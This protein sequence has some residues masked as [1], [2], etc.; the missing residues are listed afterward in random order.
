MTTSLKRAYLFNSSAGKIESLQELKKKF[1]NSC[2]I[3]GG[4]HTKTIWLNIKYLFSAI[5]IFCVWE[6]FHIKNTL[7]VS[8]IIK[9]SQKVYEVMSFWYVKVYIF[10]K[11]IQYT[12]HWDKKQ[13]LQKFTLDKMNVT[14]MHS[15]LFCGLQLTSFT[16]N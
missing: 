6:I 13:M 9:T 12:I 10:S 2:F 5:L 1:S 4:S 15:L 3:R 7:K 11:F 14:K 16:F 8:T